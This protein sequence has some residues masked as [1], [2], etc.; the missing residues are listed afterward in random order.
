LESKEVSDLFDINNHIIV[1]GN[2]NTLPM[3]IPE[4][5][6]PT[7]RG[8][9]YHPLV[10]VSPTEPERWTAIKEKYNDVYFLRG[11]LT[12]T[13]IFNKAN[14]DDAFAVILLCH[15]EDKKKEVV[16]LHLSSFSCLSPNRRLQQGVNEY[17]ADSDILFT[18]LKL[19]QYVPRNVFFSVELTCSENMAGMFDLSSTSL[20]LSLH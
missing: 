14:I 16:G 20:S 4:L 8:D 13:A 3:F 2:T 10:I 1:F 5:R 12:R 7:V 6:R 18:Y 17:N 15:R 9:T 11:S 19:E